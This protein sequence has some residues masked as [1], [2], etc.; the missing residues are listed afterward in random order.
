M[1]LQHDWRGNQLEICRLIIVRT[2]AEMG[3]L[4]DNAIVA[5][6][7]HIHVVDRHTVGDAH[8]IPY[9][10]IPRRPDTHGRIDM[11]VFADARTENP[12]QRGTPCMTWSGTRTEQQQPRPVPYLAHHAIAQR[13]RWGDSRIVALDDH[14]RLKVPVLDHALPNYRSATFASREVAAAWSCRARTLAQSSPRPKRAWAILVSEYVEI[15]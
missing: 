9:V 15:T 5:D 8:A 3:S 1:R 10:K 4:R 12:K 14:R 2:A 6:G 7:D 11:H 13:E